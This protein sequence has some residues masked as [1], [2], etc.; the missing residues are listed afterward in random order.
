MTDT[1]VDPVAANALLERRLKRAEAARAEAEALLE[2]RSRE[3]DRSNRDL[4]QREQEM[5]AQLDIGNRNLLQAQRMG[6]I[7]TFYGV[8]GESFR[9]S[10]ALADII[11]HPPGRPTTVMDV[12]Q[13]LHPLDRDRIFALQAEFFAS[14]E[15]DREYVHECR[16]VRPDLSVRW[17]RWSI[18]Q[19]LSHDNRSMISGT[20][21]DITVQRAA[22][23]R[24]AA[25]QLISQRNLQRLRRMDALLAERVVELE[26]SA[27]ALL[28]S[29]ARTEAAHVAKNQFLARMSHKIRTPMN[30]VLGMMTALAQ[31]QLDPS[32]QQQLKRA[33]AAGDELRTLIDEII[34][35]AD[36]NS[37]DRR[38]SAIQPFVDA[39]ADNVPLIVAGR[40][41]RIMVADDIETN[42]IVLASILDSIG[43]DHLVVGDGAQALAAAQLGGID[44]ILMDIQ[45]PIMDG[46]EATRQ[47]RQ[48]PGA[49]GSVPII[50]VTA[51]AIQ[52]ERDALKRA[53]MNDCLAK[54]ITMPL[55]ARVLRTVLAT[56]PVI[57]AKVFLAVMA[58]LPADRRATLFDQVARDLTQ[59]AH[60]FTAATSNDDAAGARRARHSLVGVASNFGVGGLTALLETSG[61]QSPT[62]PHA[63]ATLSNIVDAAI[64]EGRALLLRTAPHN[65]RSTDQ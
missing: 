28:E 30:G 16:I 61:D 25:L 13:V 21:Q 5:V 10:E 14:A 58:A 29:H 34:D 64:I 12:A 18:R 39:Q 45:M 59:L 36:G 26:H 31:T 17:L 24:T 54:P 55:L 42:Q 62:D 50:G 56:Q 32:Q 11:G 27:S 4:R 49:A 57:D 51:Q 35:I 20:V 22:Q 43:C 2:R 1:A 48:L 53:G 23:R 7:A 38:S 6:G 52:S 15:P 65:R 44:A 46:A 9:T 41:P 33:R 63:A 47:I 37:D 3:L 8:K 60:D 19:S 40:R